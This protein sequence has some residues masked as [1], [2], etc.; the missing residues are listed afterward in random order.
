MSWAT[1]HNIYLGL[2]YFGIAFKYLHLSWENV[3]KCLCSH[4]SFT[5]FMLPV[6]VWNRKKWIP[7]CR[8]KCFESVNTQIKIPKLMRQ[9]HKNVRKIKVETNKWH[10]Q[11]YTG[12]HFAVSFP[13]PLNHRD[14]LL[15]TGL[16]TGVFSHT[17]SKQV[18]IR[19]SRKKKT[20]TTRPFCC[21]IFL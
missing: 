11:E 5:A 6:Y 2:L 8:S 16:Q 12:S 14:F 10:K 15:F 4:T 18:L 9:E 19:Q 1:H 3:Q 17:Y 13:S 7:V 20:Q 21:T